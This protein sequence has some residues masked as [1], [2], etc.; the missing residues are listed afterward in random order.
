MRHKWL[1]KII[2]R[3]CS[4]PLSQMM[5]AL[6]ESGSDFGSLGRL[7]KSIYKVANAA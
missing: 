6:D 7:P 2:L 1:I 5:S 4:N 3:L